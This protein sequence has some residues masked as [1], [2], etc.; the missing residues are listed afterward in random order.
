[1]DWT[2]YENVRYMH[3]QANL[4]WTAASV[5]E[6]TVRRSAQVI[7]EWTEAEP[8]ELWYATSGAQ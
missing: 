3:F 8:E 1:M 5:V 2:R 6:V 7:Q 4:L